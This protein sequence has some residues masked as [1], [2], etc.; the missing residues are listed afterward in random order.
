MSLDRGP[1]FDRSFLSISAAM[2]GLGVA[3]ESTRRAVS[4]DSTLPR[5][6]LQLAQAFLDLG[7]P[8]SALAV[9][10]GGMKNAGDTAIVA[11]FA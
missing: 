9:L 11:Q 7:Q 4:E 5:G 8:D 3:L 6:Y 1:R 2:D 10:E